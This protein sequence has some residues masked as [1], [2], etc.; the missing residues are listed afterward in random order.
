MHMIK[1]KQPPGKDKNTEVQ[2]NLEIA[3]WGK[4]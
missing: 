3:K 2:K 1:K 4:T